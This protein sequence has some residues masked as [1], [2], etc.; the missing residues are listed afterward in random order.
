MLIVVTF[1]HDIYQQIN[2][3]LRNIKKETWKKL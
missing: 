2:M 1:Q 3:E